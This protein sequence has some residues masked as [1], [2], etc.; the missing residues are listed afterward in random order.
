MLRKFMEKRID[1]KNL[2]QYIG[3]RCSVKGMEIFACGPDLIDITKKQYPAEFMIIG[4]RKGKLRIG[5]RNSYSSLEWLIAIS[6]VWNL[7]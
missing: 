6:N 7:Q 4:A 2:K 3:F 5:L 1:K